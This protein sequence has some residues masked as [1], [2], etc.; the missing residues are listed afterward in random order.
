MKKIK[1]VNDNEEKLN[2]AIPNSR[3]KRNAREVIN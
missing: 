2:K 3:K 1:D